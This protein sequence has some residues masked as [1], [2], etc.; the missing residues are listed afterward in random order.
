MT[1]CDPMDCSQPGSSVHGD[2]L[3]KNTRVGCHAL[4]QGIFLTK[5]SNPDLLHCR[6]IIYY[7]SHQGIPRVLEWVAIPSPGE[8]P[9]PGIEPGSPALQ[10]D[11]L[12]AELP[13]NLP[14][15]GYLVAFHDTFRNN[16][17]K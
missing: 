12:P 8:L 7:L 2:S 13:G 6:Q 3:G 9:D 15:L 10:L 1:I 16:M 17:N 4:L 11:S 5:G 14:C